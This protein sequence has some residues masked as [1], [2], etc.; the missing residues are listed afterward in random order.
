MGSCTVPTMLTVLLTRHGMTERSQPEQHLGQKLDIRL[1]E[2]GRQAARALTTRLEHVPLE[3]VVSSPLVRASETARIA[4]PGHALETDARLMEM[5]YGDW[6]GL[7]N[8]QI[9]ERHRELRAAFEADPASV[10]CPGGESGLD[11]AGR[12]GRLLAELVAW[13]G[14]EADDHR[15]LL[16]AHSTLN[17]ILLCVALDVP[18]AEYRRRFRQ[19][20]ANLTVVRFGGS[21]G[22][23]G[24]LLLGNDLGHVR[25]LRGATW[26]Q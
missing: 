11:V 12:V 24:Q 10:S 23:G 3:R 4:L 6:E 7:T 26:D 9:D 1:S 13:A 22:P 20:W 19:E 17:R 25:G 8:E 15:V 5:D 21:Y 18:V 14:S 16:V 2:G